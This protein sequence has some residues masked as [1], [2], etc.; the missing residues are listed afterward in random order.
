MTTPTCHGCKHC[1]Y[2][3][4][5]GQSGVDYPGRPA[6]LSQPHSRCTELAVYVPMVMGEHDKWLGS[7]VPPECPVHRQPSLLGA[8]AAAVGPR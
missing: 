6:I 7:R 8:A 5:Y 3:A 1:Y 4:R 2:S